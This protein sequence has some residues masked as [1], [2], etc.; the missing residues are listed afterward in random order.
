MLLPTM[1][2]SNAATTMTEQV[3]EAATQRYLRGDKKPNWDLSG[4]MGE[5]EW[6]FL[7]FYCFYM[8]LMYILYWRDI[9]KPMKLLAVF[10]HEMVCCFVQ[11][12]KLSK[13]N[14]HLLSRINSKRFQNMIIL[15][16]LSRE[17]EY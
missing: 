10:V 17:H 3:L 7:A 11:Q 2:D 9:M 12:N 13:K 8:I 6:I 14:D 1:T 15:E 4:G 5:E 16:I